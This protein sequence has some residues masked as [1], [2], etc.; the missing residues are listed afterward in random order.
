MAVE[1][2]AGAAGAAGRG[3]GKSVVRLGASIDQAQL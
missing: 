2:A 3:E 1:G